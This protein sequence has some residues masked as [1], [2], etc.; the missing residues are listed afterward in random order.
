MIK[1]ITKDELVKGSIILFV[2]IGF[3]NLFNYIFQ[4]SMAKMLM[5]ENYGIFAVLMSFLYIFAIPFEAIQTITARYAS[6]F[7]AKKEYGKMKD[8]FYKSIK[9]IFIFSIISFFIFI[10]LAV[11]L[12]EMLK[13]SFGLLALS[14]V[15]IISSLLLPVTRGILQ[16]RKKFF[17]LGMNFMVE[18]IAKVIIALFLVL[19][20]WKVYGAITSVLVAEMIAFAF[21]FYA[22]KDVRKSKRQKGNYK[23]I[24]SENY[25][26]LVAITCV[27]LIYSIDVI[28]ARKVFSA[29]IAGIYAFVSLI[30]K[31]IFFSCSAVGK[32]MLPIS[33]EE[34]ESG[35]GTKRILKKAFLL[36]FAIIFIALLLYLLFPKEIV[37]ILS[38]GTEEYLVGSNVLFILGMAFS[39]LSFTYLVLMHKVATNK[40]GKS[41]YFLFMFVILEIALLSIFNADL[42]QFSL[43]LLVVNIVMFLYALFVK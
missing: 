3:Y 17:A 41:S 19:I 6:K 34:Y 21:L 42:M 8:F 22:L 14:G 4:V 31:V 35:K 12:S 16:G 11:Y 26:G 10:I 27:V 38:L 13:I 5:P 39:F 23:G 28:I 43:S 33:S 20:G 18:G 9:K 32:A 1:K 40:L 7:N 37:R 30:G 29:E 2:M 24:Y 15:F 36:V 25:Q